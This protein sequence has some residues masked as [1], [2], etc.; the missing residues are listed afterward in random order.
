MEGINDIATGS[1]QRMQLQAELQ[2]SIVGHRQVCVRTRNFNPVPVG[3]VMLDVR[4]VNMQ[5]PWKSVVKVNRGL[6]V[7]AE[8]AYTSCCAHSMLVQK[9]TP[10]T[11]WYRAFQ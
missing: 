8:V 3:R 2:A 5:F 4:G 10:Q 9:F 1:T 11:P 6:L 7:R